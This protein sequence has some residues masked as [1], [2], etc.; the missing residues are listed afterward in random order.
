[1]GLESSIV[2]L[3]EAVG[4]FLSSGRKDSTGILSAAYLVNNEIGKQLKPAENPSLRALQLKVN[5]VV[6]SAKKL[7]AQALRTSME[8]VRSEALLS[9]GTG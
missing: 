2:A 6:V 8:K 1:M 4:K 9:R 5:D 7:D 3:D